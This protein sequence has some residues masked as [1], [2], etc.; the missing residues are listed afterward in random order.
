MH[1]IFVFAQPHIAIEAGSNFVRCHH[2]TSERMREKQNESRNR[3]VMRIFSVW[4]RSWYFICIWNSICL[5]NYYSKL[6]STAIL[7]SGVLAVQNIHKVHKWSSSNTLN[8]C[9][10]MFLREICIAFIGP[11]QHEMTQRKNRWFKFV[12]GIEIICV[13]WPISISPRQWH[14]QMDDVS[15]IQL[16]FYT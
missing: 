12:L 2:N 13:R 5:Y 9:R 1:T 4:F 15:L 14:H 11:S 7:H 3:H 8:I 6:I 10:G 16:K